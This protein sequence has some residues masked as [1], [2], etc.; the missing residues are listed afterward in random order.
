MSF[1]GPVLFLWTPLLL[2]GL[3]VVTIVSSKSKI[4][5]G[6]N[7]TFACNVTGSPTPTVRWRTEEIY[8]QFELKVGIELK[9]KH[10]DIVALPDGLSEQLRSA[11]SFLI[12]RSPILACC[13]ELGGLLYSRLDPKPVCSLCFLQENI[14]GS[15]VELLLYLTN[16]SSHDN[17]HNLTCEA[18][19]QAGPAEEMVQLDIECKCQQNKTLLLNT[20]RLNTS[21]R[22]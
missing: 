7:L 3:P 15:T 8:S 16:V 22:A 9:K 11:S 1:L 5:E 2:S 4:Q 20:H 18:E 14:W 19:N 17:L 6:G 10:M 21:C 12:K 13:K